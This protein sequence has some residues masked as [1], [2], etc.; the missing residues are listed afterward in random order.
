MSSAVAMWRATGSST[1]RSRLLKGSAR[2]RPRL[3]AP[4]TR[5]GERS[6]TVASARVGDARKSAVANGGAS[7]SPSHQAVGRSNAQATSCAPKGARSRRLPAS[8][9]DQLER[10]VAPG[11]RS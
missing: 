9:R 10:A 5:S 4:I 11:R 2:L 6:G 1:A 3:S 8:H 7:A